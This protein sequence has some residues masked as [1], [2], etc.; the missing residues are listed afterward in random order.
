MGLGGILGFSESGVEAL[1]MGDAI[2][3]G[4]ETMG[5]SIALM[6]MVIGI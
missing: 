5:A 3:L 4:P 2:A 6:G 1:L